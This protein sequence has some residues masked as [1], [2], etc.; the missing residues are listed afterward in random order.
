MQL[1]EERLLANPNL[2]T[3]PLPLDMLM[4][5]IRLCVIDCNFSYDNRFFKQIRGLPM[6]SP[7]SPI[8]ANI[9]MEFFEDKVLKDNT[10]INKWLRFV[11]DVIAVVPD[12]TDINNLNNRLNSY[13]NS[14]K[15]KFE[16]ENNSSLPFLD[17]LVI[18][19][20]V[21]HHPIFK[22]YRKPT[23]CNSYI[24]AFSNHHISVKLGTM[25][26]IFLRALRICDS[27]F[28]DDEN[29]YIFDSF[30]KLGY[31][32]ILIDKAFYCARKTYY[33]ANSNKKE[34]DYKNV[35]VIPA[36][37]DSEYLN[38]LITNSGY[39]I[40]YKTSTTLTNQFSNKLKQRPDSDTP[41]IYQVPCRSCQPPSS[42]FGETINHDKRQ[43]QHQYSIRTQ[44]SNNAIVKHMLDTNHTVL[45]SDSQVIRKENNTNKRKIIES[46]IIS[47]KSNFSTQKSNYNL[48]K[49]TNNLVIRNCPK[50]HNTF[51]I[52]DRNLLNLTNDT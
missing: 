17:C 15:F 2:N 44:D 23:H 6:G 38:K 19:D 50:L 33:G 14:I 1:L 37:S 16:V 27:Q 46:I 18:K 42:Y 28:I 20:P 43:K 4:K 35:L 21:N 7:I 49:L 22:I 31:S 25:A 39:T 36:L 26:N 40:V 45:M 24:H 34:R 48:D 52:I 11:D 8:I 41:V 47:N 51:S 32:Q 30:K 9:F 10:C 5:L 12:D 29:K 3:L 13:H